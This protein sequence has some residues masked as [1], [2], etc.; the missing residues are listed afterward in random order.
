M[1]KHEL[2]SNASHVAQDFL[3]PLG[4]APD[5]PGRR[6]F[7]V[8]TTQCTHRKHAWNVIGKAH[9]MVASARVTVHQREDLNVQQL[10][11]EIRLGCG[12][13]RGQCPVSTFEV[14][15]LILVHHPQPGQRGSG[16]TMVNQPH[17]P[18]GTPPSAL[19]RQLATHARHVV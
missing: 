11:E 19:A 7:V 13:S 12:Y 1:D 16:L 17:A 2:S 4:T 6:R 14:D 8:T 5:L 18:A 3:D 15:V 9:G 10:R